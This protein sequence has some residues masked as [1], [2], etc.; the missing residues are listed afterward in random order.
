MAADVKA[1][2]S[3]ND[4]ASKYGVSLNTVYSACH[5]FGVRLKPGTRPGTPSPRRGVFSDTTY[6]ILEDLASGSQP[7]A[8]ARLRGV[9]RQRV[10]QI[11]VRAFS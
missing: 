7:S 3:T 11:K 10:H 1:G 9:S 2:A 5:E 4:V 6:L 8:V